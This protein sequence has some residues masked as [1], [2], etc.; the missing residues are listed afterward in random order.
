MTGQYTPPKRWDTR[1]RADA[2]DPPDELPPLY[3]PDV[4]ARLFREANARLIY[5]RG[6]FHL[7]GGTCYQP[8][9]RKSGARVAAFITE[10]GWWGRRPQGRIGLRG[11]GRSAPGLRR[12]DGGAG[13]G[14]PKTAHI[15][16]SS[17]N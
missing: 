12:P 11:S 7:Y 2:A 5:W 14:R 3:R 9:A 16:R 4:V 15:A 6:V 1:S 8:L 10:V 17:C 13:E